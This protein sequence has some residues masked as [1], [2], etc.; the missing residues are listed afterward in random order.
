MLFR[1]RGVT[2]GQL[3]VLFVVW[4]VSSFLFEV[5]SGAWADTH[6]P[7]RVLATSAVCKAMAFACWTWRP[8]MPGFVAG[9]VLW[10]TSSALVSGTFEAYTYASLDALGQAHRYPGFIGRAHTVTQL[11]VL[12]G[13]ALGGPLFALGGY[14]LAGV[15]STLVCVMTIPLALDLPP[16]P[17]PRADG[18]Q[19][20]ERARLGYGAALRSGLAE[21]RHRPAVRRRAPRC[22]ARRRADRVRRVTSRSSLATTGPPVPS[23]RCCV[24][25]VTVGQVVGTASA[26]RAARLRRRPRGAMYACG[27]ALLAAGAGLGGWLGFAL[28][29]AG[30][31]LL[32]SVMLATEARL[33]ALITGP[34]QATVTSVGGVGTELT[35]LTV[36]LAFGIG[37]YWWTTATLLAMA[38]VPTAAIGA[39]IARRPP[40]PS[41]AAV[42]SAHPQ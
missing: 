17:A 1:D 20:P 26:G 35:A 12:V 41:V 10:A 31:G 6:D 38:V 30:Y 21:V 25:V 28:M 32:N 4:S 7:R 40:P 8:S 19:H 42:A 9:F 33:Q 37:H 3:A 24:A 34:A 16:P 2:D 23:F 36:Y 15:V 5:P 14:R 13:I 22:V 39:L 29:G 27:G 18:E 11:A